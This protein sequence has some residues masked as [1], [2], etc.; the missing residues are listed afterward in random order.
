M[1]DNETIK[2]ILDRYRQ[3]ILVIRHD[4]SLDENGA[5]KAIQ[6]IITAEVEKA[7]TSLLE[8][9]EKKINN[10]AEKDNLPDLKAIH[11]DDLKK[12][13]EKYLLKKGE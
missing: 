10:I 3:R 1:N 8:E 5:I 13:A 4:D 7:I 11:I 6:Q 2:D 12:I 9:A